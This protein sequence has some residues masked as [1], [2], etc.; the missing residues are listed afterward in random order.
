MLNFGKSTG[1]FSPIFDTL[2]KHREMY[3][4]WSRSK[5]FSS[6]RLSLAFQLKRDEVSLRISF[7]SLMLDGDKM[8]LQRNSINEIFGEENSPT[9]YS[10]KK[11]I[12][13]VE[14]PRPASGE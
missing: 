3:Q 13:V 4:Q 6:I 14:N 5:A 10:V 7:L 9:A 1:R 11:L 8:Q 2:V 12:A